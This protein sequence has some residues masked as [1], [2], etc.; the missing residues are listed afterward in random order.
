MKKQQGVVLLA[1]LLVMLMMS[2]ISIA[3]LQITQQHERMSSNTQNRNTAMMAANSGAALFY[4]WL[5]ADNWGNDWTQE[6][7]TQ[8]VNIGGFSFYYIESV[9][10][11]NT[12]DGEQVTVV[13]VGQS[14][15][16]NTVLAQASVVTVIARVSSVN[17]VFAAG[18]LA[19]GDITIS[20]GS[21]F[22][23]SIHSN[24]DFINSGASVLRD[25]NSTDTNGNTVANSAS[26]S[27]QGTANFSGDVQGTG[28]VAG[29]TAA[30]DVPSAAAFIQSQLLSAPV[31]S[32][33]SIPTGNLFGAIYYCNTN[34]TVASGSYSNGTIMAQGD[35]TFNGAG[36]LGAQGESTLAIVSAGNITVNGSTATAGVF[37]SEGNL[38][39]NGSSTLSGS[40]IAG[41]SITR[42]GSFI[43]T[44][45]SVGTGLPLPR[46]SGIVVASW[47]EKG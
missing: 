29:N 17:P 13:T 12:R 40:I 25:W 35:I 44:Q 1:G 31:I 11:S 21:V 20:G 36:Q 23:G 15:A 32:S 43:Y 22:N 10:W 2:V 16:D 7:A 14:R 4:N 19:E 8:P 27:A 9:A 37:W 28:G 5:A 42:N 30:V 38:R 41:G 47:Y 3:L 26:V 34:L 33:C 45:T 6:L 24:G 18:M 46:I 39:Q